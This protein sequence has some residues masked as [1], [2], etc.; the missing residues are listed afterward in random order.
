MRR[1]SLSSSLVAASLLASTQVWAQG[2]TQPK[3]PQPAPT[4]SQAAPAAQTQPAAESA[5]STTAEVAA[6][7]PA[8]TAQ[9]P[10]PEDLL[11]SHPGGLTAQQVGQRAMST[12]FAA[13]Q[14]VETMRA[15]EARV[16]QAWAGFLP[17]LSGLA[18]YTRLSSFTPPTIP[19][20]VPGVYTIGTTDPQYGQA[21]H[22]PT[23]TVPVT[24]TN[25]LPQ[26]PGNSFAIPNEPISFALIVDQWLLQGTLTVPISDYFLRI[27]QSYTAAQKSAEAA[28]Y[29]IGAARVTAL[30]NG[31]VAYYSWLQARGQVIVGV[32]ALN[33]QR[34]HLN[35]ARNQF[36]VGNASKADVL[37]AE[38][39]VASA[40]LVVV[41]AENAADLA[42]KQMRIAMHIPDSQKI[43]PGEGLDQQPAPFGGQL[44]G[45][46]D[47]GVGQRFELKSIR[48]NAV[49]A[50]KTAEA[51]TAGRY[52]VISAFGDVIEGNPNPRVFPA[53]QTWFPTWDVGVQATWSPNDILTANGGASDYIAR[54]N[55][56]ESQVQVTLEGIQV[57]ITQAFQTLKAAEFSLDS[58]KRELA[59]ATEA[60]RVAHE[61]FNNGRGTSTT[62]ADAEHELAIARIDA[63]NAQVNARIARVRLEHAVGRDLKEIP[64]NP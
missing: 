12:S 34:T 36:Q 54:A 20:G 8:S 19:T 55:A 62:L 58:T 22:A 60:Y 56:L 52:P 44:Q 4:S 3:A 14:S 37:R 25:N 9:M 39:A 42:E 5:P 16:D 17:R 41:Q 53:S 23:P 26:N 40:E 61:L 38:T 46:I 59:S 28:R 48:T 31:K 57:E 30:T 49:A 43:V 13:K 32:Q 27:G 10:V 35:D 2:G 47:E 24:S 29:D 11:R 64:A 50:R 51:N 45:L 21:G 6:L 63:L 18:R 15:A 33:D 7:T 1:S